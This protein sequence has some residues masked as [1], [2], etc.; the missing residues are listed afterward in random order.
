[1][2]C[3]S[4]REFLYAGAVLSAGYALPSFARTAS[5][6]Q[7]PVSTI[8][9]LIDEFV[10]RRLQ[11]LNAPGMILSLATKTGPIYSSGYGFADVKAKTPVNQQHLFE[12]GSI[13]KSITAIC[14]LQLVDE[15]KLDLHK[16]VQQYLPW[17]Q[18]DSGAIPVTTHHLL[19]HTS[20]LP[21]WPP[22]GPRT[23]YQKLW[24]GF[25]P[26]KEFS[27]SNI[28]YQIAGMVLERIEGKQ[29]AEII[30]QRVLSPLKMD[31]SEPIIT[32]EIRPRVAI[33]Y[34]DPMPDFVHP[35]RGPLAEAPWV[36]MTYASGCVA[37][38]AGD[39][40]KYM[41]ALLNH[42]SV[43]DA[44]V[45]T[46]QM[47][48]LMTK[49]V[50]EA[51]DFGKDAQYGYGLAVDHIQGRTRLRHTGG[52]VAFSSAMHVDLTDSI[53]GFASTNCRLDGY[54]P[55]EI[56]SYA[57][58]LLRA[59]NAGKPLPEAPA[60]D[61][62]SVVPNAKD[63]AGNYGEL[64]IRAEGN[65]LTAAINVDDGELLRGGPDRF[66]HSGNH[67]TLSNTP[68]IHTAGDGARGP[69]PIVFERHDGQV[70]EAFTPA[71]WFPNER[72]KGPMKFDYPREW[73]SFVGHY[74]NN[75]PWSGSARV[76]LQKGRLSLEGTP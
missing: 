67:A 15:G 14:A 63:Y 25:E 22:L 23:P 32:S 69:W 37:S 24:V 65:K 74:T 6:Q 62:P 13:S 48:D 7:Q 3:L 35:P 47:F 5:V 26:G 52:M 9:P 39:M 41:S 50:H 72:Y 61:N 21:G 40:G 49:P 2:A 38:T 70:V 20:G 8:I 11:E 33:G 27:Y 44:R 28:G 30:R 66:I 59:A 34:Q 19:S 58:D 43:A 73:D 56:C 75:N 4:R 68:G 45:L 31:R 64:Q 12:I 46:P 76:Y 36:E 53:A 71:G 18:I 54:R 10:N 51:P 17:L 29:L 42:G 1:M 16:P 57:L 55:N 60:P